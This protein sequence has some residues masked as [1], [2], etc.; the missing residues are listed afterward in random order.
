MPIGAITSDIDVTEVVLA[1]FF[2]FFLGLVYHLRQE[3][4]REGYP[5]IDTTNGRRLIGFPVPPSPKTFKLLDGGKAITPRIDPPQPVAARALHNFPG[6]PLTPTGD[7]LRDGVGPAAYAQ[8]RDEPLIFGEGKI[9]V[10]PMRTLEDWEV[11]EGATDPRGMAVIS[12]DGKSVGVVRDL[13]IDRSVKILRYLEVE[14]LSP[15]RSALVPIY[16][17]NIKANRRR[18]LVKALSARQFAEAPDLREPDRITAREEDRVN[19]YYAG[20]AFFGRRYD[21]GFAI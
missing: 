17:T 10:L 9:Q 16:Y 21:S 15:A 14:L 12:A 8:R 20:A 6:A 19:A 3:D 18:I 7:P 11:F 13:W 5:A 4:K 1:A 2:L